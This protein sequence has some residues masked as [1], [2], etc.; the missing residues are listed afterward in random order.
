MRRMRTCWPAE[1]CS[2]MRS[3]LPHT[4]LKL[5]CLQQQQQPEEREN[6]SWERRR[7][8]FRETSWGGCRT[9]STFCIK[10][11]LPALRWATNFRQWDSVQE[12]LEA[13]ETREGAFHVMKWKSRS[14]KSIFPFLAFSEIFSV[15]NDPK[16]SLTT[17]HS[18]FSSF[19]GCLFD[20][21]WHDSSDSFV[22]VLSSSLELNWQFFVLLYL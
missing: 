22:Q 16:S 17:P 9:H 14:I 11:S 7:M 19:W 1:M 12:L 10:D 6:A 18:P 4:E 8:P 13:D 21:M 20:F 15:E 2:C 5:R 3:A